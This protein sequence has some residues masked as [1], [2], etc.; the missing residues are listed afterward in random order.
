MTYSKCNSKYPQWIKC[1][2]RRVR[3]EALARDRAGGRVGTVVRSLYV[4]WTVVGF[5]L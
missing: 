5:I 4:R 1:G 2:C 3:G